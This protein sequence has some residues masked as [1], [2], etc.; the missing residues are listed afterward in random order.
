MLFI[1]GATG[2]LGPDDFPDPVG[3][4]LI[5][6]AGVALIA[7]GV[8]L[9]RLSETIDL[10]T[11]ALA[12]AATAAAAVVWRVAATGFS[13]A[14]SALVVATATALAILASLQL[15]G[16]RFGSRWSG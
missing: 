5:M 13:S 16:S 12:N 2:L 6:A 14:G 4:P 9:W 3:T 1:G 15:S 7:T 11:L 8:V 10:R